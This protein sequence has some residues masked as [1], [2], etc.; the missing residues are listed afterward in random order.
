MKNLKKLTEDLKK[1]FGDALWA[2]VVK[3]FPKEKLKEVP[4]EMKDKVKDMT[5]AVIND[6]AYKKKFN[7][8][9]FGEEV[10][11]LPLSG[12]WQA[13]YDGKYGL[14]EDL[15]RSE[16]IYDYGIL[17][18]LAKVFALRAKVIEKFA[19]GKRNYIMSMILFGSWA[20]GEARKDSD[21]DV[22]FVIDDTDVKRMTREEVRMRIFRMIAGDAA[23]IDTNFN[24]QVYVLTSFWESIRD[25][26]PVIFTLLRD[27]VPVYDQGLFMP[28]RI[29]LKTGKIKPTPEAIDNF[30]KSSEM[31]R[32][33]VKR[34]L[35]EMVIER[36]YYSILNLAQAALMFY[37]VAP[38][39]HSETPKLVEEYFVKE[40]LL[41]KKYARWIQEIVKVRKDVEH[42]KRKEEITGKEV[43]DWLK[44][45]EEIEKAMRELIDKLT[46]K[47]VEDKIKKVEELIND[48]IDD[49]FK[50]LEV[51]PGKD[52]L[53]TLAELVST[54]KVPESFLEFV[55]SFESTKKRKILYEEANRIER[56]ATAI[57]KFVLSFVESL[58]GKEL[59]KRRVRVKCE[60]KVGEIWFF[61]DKVYIIKDIKEPEKIFVANYKDGKIGALKEATIE[62]FKK[63][64]KTVEIGKGYTINDE[65]FKSIERIFGK[66]CKVMFE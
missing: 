65:T 15:V 28:W 44:K 41:D 31:L 61:S 62:D 48:T 46:S 10:N 23:E 5:I 64:K 36:L 43:D 54:G 52:K 13:L 35:R 32:K 22:A 27:G 60:K 18:V 3:K 45:S 56:D 9:K 7:Y 14:V 6:L 47:V 25:A 37:G 11:F 34:D 55:E 58:R 49:L 26:H 24:I 42:G 38:P 21:I 8:E 57:C 40:G 2:V 4:P 20:R 50:I 33:S 19:T 17:K 63:A 59:L 1:E 39:V 51:E 16:I 29:L 30:L 66:E 12:M 53:K